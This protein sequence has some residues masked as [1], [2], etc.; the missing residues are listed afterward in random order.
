MKSRGI[1]NS[2]KEVEFII[3][4]E[5]ISIAP[6]DMAMLKKENLSAPKNNILPETKHNGNLKKTE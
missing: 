6:L 2:K 4:F 1:S 3:T 5:G